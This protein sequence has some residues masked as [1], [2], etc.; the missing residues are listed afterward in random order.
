MKDRDILAGIEF[1]HDV[2]VR[3]ISERCRQL[4]VVI[5]EEFLKSP[6]NGYFVMYTQ[7]LQIEQKKRKIIPCVQERM[8][9]PNNLRY[10]STLDYK[11]AN[12]LYNFWNKLEDAIKDKSANATR[13]SNQPSIT[14][15]PNIVDAPNSKV[16]IVSEPLEKHP[17]E[18]NAKSNGTLVI[19]ESSC[20]S[21][22]TSNCSTESPKALFKKKWYTIL[23]RATKVNQDKSEDKPEKKKKWYKSNKKIATAL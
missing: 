4:I 15:T 18:S 19:R 10:Y 16:D 5:S 13:Q 2:F 6:L 22:K 12:K 21:E 9:L 14:I 20:N 3:L 1:E 8:Q 23:A 7:A 17:E 11:R